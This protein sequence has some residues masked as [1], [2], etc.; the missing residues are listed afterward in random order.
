MSK[1]TETIETKSHAPL[2]GVVLSVFEKYTDGDLKEEE[3]VLKAEIDAATE[4]LSSVENELFYRRFPNMRP[5]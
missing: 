3:R 4:R 5:H 2:S 1:E